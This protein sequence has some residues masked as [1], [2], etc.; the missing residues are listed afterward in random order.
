MRSDASIRIL[1]LVM[2]FLFG[3]LAGHVLLDSPVPDRD[4]VVETR[5]F[6]IV[7]R[8]P[9]ND[10][11]GASSVTKWLALECPS[12]SMGSTIRCDDYLLVSNRTKHGY[13]LVEGRV[14]VFNNTYSDTLVA[15]RLVACLDENCTRLVFKGD[16]N[17]R[18]D[19]FVR[20]EDVQYEVLGVM[21][22]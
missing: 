2:V 19:P 12:D 3:M 15:H 18:A 22:G 8:E 11:P 10:A 6:P 9:V 1:G 20:R 7:E 13:P 21:Y 16:N 17:D 14:Y 5:S 4:V